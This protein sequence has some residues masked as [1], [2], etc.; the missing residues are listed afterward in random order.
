MKYKYRQPQ[1]REYVGNEHGDLYLN[2]LKYF[3]FHS[4]PG[5]RLHKIWAVAT[6]LVLLFKIDDM[7]AAHFVYGLAGIYVFY[8]AIF[9]HFLLIK[10]ICRHKGYFLYPSS[11][12]KFFK[13]R[14]KTV[15]IPT[16]N[17]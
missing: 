9:T 12:V 1:H 14:K 5:E 6:M 7:F 2:H 4:Y 3:E 15:D 13:K 16:L 8:I 11:F 17:D 10:K